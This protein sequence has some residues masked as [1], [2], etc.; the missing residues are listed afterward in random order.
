MID[1]K[2]APNCKAC[3][4]EIPWRKGRST[5]D[6]KKRVFCD[7]KCQNNEKWKIQRFLREY[8]IDDNGCWITRFAKI[9]SGYGYGHV[10]LNGKVWLASRLAYYLHSG[11]LTE[12]SHICHK[13]DNPP[14][15][16]PDH[17]YEGNAKT[18]AQDK[19]DRNRYTT[20]RGIDSPT[21]RLTEEQVFAILN[22]HRTYKEICEEYPVNQMTISNI[23]KGKRY[24]PTYDTWRNG[25]KFFCEEIIDE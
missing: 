23:K 6:W 17:L 22:D 7:R 25:L 4:G 1:R 16:N 19:K 15:I 11:E 24:K 8:D 13:C 5:A 18:N 20:P 2:E 9:K 14:C 10:N 21:A 12:G 3:G